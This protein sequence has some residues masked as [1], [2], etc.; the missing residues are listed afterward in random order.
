VTAAVAGMRWWGA[1][2]PVALLLMTLT[3]N[4]GHAADE[5]AAAPRAVIQTLSRRV[6]STLADNKDKLRT[7]AA[8][9]ARTI[10]AIVDPYLDFNIMSEEVLGVAW[11]RADPRQRAR[12]TQ[13]FHQL[14]TNDYVAVFKQYDGQ[15]IN[16]T[17]ARWQDEAQDRAT[18]FSDVVSPGEQAVKVEYRIHKSDGQWK[19]YDVV[20]D[21]VSLLI[22]YRVAFDSELQHED[23]DALITQI[24]RKTSAQQ[25]GAQVPAP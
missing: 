24:Q 9:V 3:V 4:T 10:A 21:D 18:V 15:S 16:V 19:I 6:L 8:D 12:F 5:A 13:A 7:A 2:V 11:R 20:V 25:S 23:L 14:L 17:G 1:A 22:N